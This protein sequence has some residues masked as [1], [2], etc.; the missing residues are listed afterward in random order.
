MAL[1]VGVLLDSY[2][3][4]PMKPQCS[5]SP[6]A[7]GNLYYSSRVWEAV[8]QAGSRLFSQIFFLYHVVILFNTFECFVSV[9]S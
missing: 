4:D 9:L 5:R 2:K 8:W 3:R 6:Q 7:F 1:P